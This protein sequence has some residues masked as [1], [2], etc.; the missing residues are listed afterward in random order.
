MSDLFRLADI[1]RARPQPLVGPADDGQPPEGFFANRSIMMLDPGA[2]PQQDFG[3]IVA[4]R[5]GPQVLIL[6]DRTTAGDPNVWSK[7]VID[8]AWEFDV[9]AVYSTHHPAF[10]FIAGILRARGLPVPVKQRLAPWRSDAEAVASLYERGLVRHQRPLEQLEAQLLHYGA[11][12]HLPRATA[13]IA[14]VQ[15]L[16]VPAPPQGIYPVRL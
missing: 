9:E 13:A 6:A 4:A 15:Q 7:A 5:R 10:E 8:A 2:G 14:A 11:R 16:H 1:H 12:E 3:M